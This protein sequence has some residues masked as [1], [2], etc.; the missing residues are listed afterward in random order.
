MESFIFITHL[1]LLIRSWNL[2]KRTE[3]YCRKVFQNNNITIKIILISKEMA[4]LKILTQF[5]K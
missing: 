5:S 3:K 1:G 4:E 2:R